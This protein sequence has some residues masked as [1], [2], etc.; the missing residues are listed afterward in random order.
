[1]QHEPVSFA[2]LGARAAAVLH[3]NDQ[4]EWTKAAPNLYPHQWSW[5]AAFIAIGWAHLDTARAA[6]E[7]RTLFAAQWRTGKIPH[8]VFNPD[9]AADHYFPDA[10]FWECS[11]RSPDVPEAIETSGLLQP[12]VHAI[13][14]WRIWEIAQRKGGADAEDADAFLREAYPHLR[15]WHRYLLTARDPEGTGLVATFHP[16]EG[17]DNSPRWDKALSRIQVGALAPFTR[18]DIKHVQDLSQ[19][20]TDDDYRRYLW[21]V[22]LLKQ[23]NYDD[24]AIYAEHPYVIQ[25]VFM[26]GILVAANGA[27]QNI[28]SVVGAP[29]EDRELI[30]EWI[31]RG[32]RGL[33]ARWDAERGVTFD[34]DLRSGEPIRILTVAGFAPL[35]AGSPSPGHLARQLEVFDSPAFCGHPEFRWPLPPSTS[36]VEPSFQPRSYWRGPTWPFL[37]WL[38]WWALHRA[39]QSERAERI[40]RSSLEQLSAGGFAEYFEPFTGEPLGS[41]NQAWTA[42]VTLD[43]LAAAD[44]T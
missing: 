35:I 5:D 13:A 2:D 23:R 15:A 30:R 10:S 22:E 12:P 21:L 18:A 28:A 36:P 11:H 31:E 14:A 33:A 9:V 40:R 32:H 17:L 39:G 41:S 16:W 19:R 24:A 29:A 44:T 43:W 42:A 25:D 3:L 38:F 8:I 4:G 20:P 26:S 37:N 34:F 6:Q 7:L 27:L 1:M